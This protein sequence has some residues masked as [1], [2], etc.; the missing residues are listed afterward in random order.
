MSNCILGTIII[1][2]CLCHRFLLCVSVCVA[3][4]QRSRQRKCWSL[5]LM[6]RLA[7]FLTMRSSWAR[8][9]LWA[10]WRSGTSRM[11]LSRHAGVQQCAQDTLSVREDVF[12][13]VCHPQL[14]AEDHCNRGHLVWKHGVGPCYRGTYSTSSC[15]LPFSRCRLGIFLILILSSSS[16]STENDQSCRLSR[17]SVRS[18]QTDRAILR[19][20]GATASQQAPP[21]VLPARA[22]PTP[23]RGPY[24][25]LANC[26]G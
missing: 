3:V 24:E 7:R 8:A 2:V 22:Y 10:V 18:H 17:R 16:S 15:L 19:D 13:V 9:S 14:D 11:G 5:W 21:E 4:L 23:P 1:V 26:E 6:C 12:D 25:A 20:L